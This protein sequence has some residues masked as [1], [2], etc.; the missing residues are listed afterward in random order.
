MMVHVH[1]NLPMNWLNQYANA[2]LAII[3]QITTMILKPIYAH[4]V[5]MDVLVTQQDVAIVILM[6]S[7]SM[8]FTV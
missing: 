7:V 5:L 1:V 8:S 4:L 2:C 6:L 3:L